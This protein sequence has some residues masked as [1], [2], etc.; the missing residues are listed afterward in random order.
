MGQPPAEFTFHRF[1]GPDMSVVSRISLP[2]GDHEALET[3]RVKYRS[4]N[5]IRRALG[6][7]AEVINCGSVIRRS[8]GPDD[9]ASNKMEK[10][11]EKQTATTRRRSFIANPVGIFRFSNDD[12]IGL[13][14]RVDDAE[15]N[16]HEGMRDEFIE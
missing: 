12:G 1:C 14:S 2:S 9:W 13:C 16:W 6:F 4:S 5:G 15:S 8:S 3:D 11:K 7:E 10:C